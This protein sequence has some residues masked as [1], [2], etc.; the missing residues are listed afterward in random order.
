M[1]MEQ[2]IVSTVAAQPLRKRPGTTVEIGLALEVPVNDATIGDWLSVNNGGAATPVVIRGGNVDF[3]PSDC[4]L[5]R[6]CTDGQAR[7]ST[8]HTQR[9]NYVKYFHV[10][11]CLFSAASQRASNLTRILLAMA[12]LRSEYGLPVGF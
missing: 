9:R 12:E 4:Q 3:K 8:T 2:R 6:K 7:S 10:D 1:D 11:E 5:S